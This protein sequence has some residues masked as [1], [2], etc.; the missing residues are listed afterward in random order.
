ML[1]RGRSACCQQ[2]IRIIYLA[3]ELIGA[4][5]FAMVALAI[6]PTVFGLLTG[7]VVMLLL[8]MARIDAVEGFVPDALLFVTTA[9]AYLLALSNHG[10]G[11]EHALIAHLY[12]FFGLYCVFQAI[13]WLIKSEAMGMADYHLFGIAAVLLGSQVGW[14]FA[15]LIPMLIITQL[16]KSFSK[17]QPGVFARLVGAKA[18]PAG[19][20]IVASTLLVMVMKAN[21]LIP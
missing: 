17:W 12:T 19:P 9:L 7:I 1:L 10:V 2:P 8:L 11:V 20:A 13:G 5:T 14:V 21:A 3:M 16:C 4:A 6:G 18:L 15:V